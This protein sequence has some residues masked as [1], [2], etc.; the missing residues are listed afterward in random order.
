MF[1]PAPSHND[2]SFLSKD[3]RFYV[4]DVNQ[5][6]S[7]ALRDTGFVEYPTIH[8]YAPG[9]FKGIVVNRQGVVTRVTED[10]RPTKRRRTDKKKSTL[11][12]KGLVGGY[13][14]DEETNEDEDALAI[15]GEYAVSDDGKDHSDSEQAAESL[16]EDTDYRTLLASVLKSDMETGDT[17]EDEEASDQGVLDEDEDEE[18]DR[19]LLA[20]LER[21]NNL[22]LVA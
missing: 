9:T 12:M 14:S 7:T 10:E 1:L 3:A 15:L 17:V 21:R 20:E 2:N 5:T 19:H 18:A 4:L 22:R 8:V 11:M 13:G 16:A 6:L